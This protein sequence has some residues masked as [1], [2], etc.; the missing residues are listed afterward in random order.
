MTAKPWVDVA[1]ARMITKRTARTLRR[2]R[3]QGLVRFKLADDDRTILMNT[4]DLVA[5]DEEKTAYM[6]RPTFGRTA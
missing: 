1:E 2:W 5:T 3:E 4:A 6:T